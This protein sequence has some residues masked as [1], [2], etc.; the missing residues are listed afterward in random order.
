[1]IK[2]TICLMLTVLLLFGVTGCGGSNKTNTVEGTESA[3]EL[4][5]DAVEDTN[6]S[7]DMEATEDEQ[8]DYTNILVVYFSRTG[9]TEPLAQYAA[10]YLNADIFEIEA[11]VPYTDEDIAYYTD[12]RADKEQND[13][14]A[15]PEI[16][17][18]VSNIDQ[19]DT[20]VL[21]YPIWHGQAP[22]IIDTFMESY[23]FDGKTIVPFC[24][25]HSSGIG[26][27]DTYLHGL[28]SGD[29]NWMA[30]KRFE[31]GTSKDT[32]VQW[33][34]SLGI[35]PFTKG[36][37]ETETGGENVGQFDFKNHQVLLNSGYVMPINGIGTY[38]LLDETCVSSVKEALRVGVRLIDTAYMYHNEKEVGQAIR[39]AMEEYDIKR[40]EIFVI[41]KLYPGEQYSNPEAAIEQALEKLD[42]GYIDMMLLHHPGT[43]DVQAYLA[44]EKY[45]E[46]GKIRSLGVSCFYI[47][48]LD[49]FLPQVN[50]KP[51]L[52][53][54][55]IHPYYQDSEVVDYI[56]SLGIT[57]QCWYPLG[58][59]GYTAEL[60]GNETIKAIAEE[61]GVSAAQVIL[62][63]DLQNGV[64]VIPGS[65]NPD[66][67]YENTQL[68]H[69]S[70][71]DEEMAAIKALN[72]DEKHD[73]Y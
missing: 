53:Q 25:S 22:R 50:I 60:L 1:M 44:M 67:I 32:M 66:H 45:V 71:T 23:D 5:T 59:R 9:T 40:E 54:N 43:N 28:V 41:T 15:R 4:I 8:M 47:K 10:E 72:R 69:F 34:D 52:V 33:L 73:W 35:E 39:E 2:R 17:G 58:G 27:S 11:A 16:A 42:I 49:N 7:A 38:S 70:L 14:S 6:V 61:H 18:T 13:K 21:G 46:E 29:V 57:A 64:V 48:E 62:R 65:S 55:E 3:P 68:Y 51:A 24:T 12:C 37:E 56:H 36:A 26:S 30:G 20:I 31:A 19:Y 63:W